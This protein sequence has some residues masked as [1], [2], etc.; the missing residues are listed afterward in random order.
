MKPRHLRGEEYL[1]KSIQLD[2][3]HKNLRLAIRPLMEKKDY[4]MT[5]RRMK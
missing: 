4:G 5:P 2:L 3:A 1:Q